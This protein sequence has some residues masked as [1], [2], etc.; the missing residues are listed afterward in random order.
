MTGNIPEKKFRAGAVSVTVWRNKSQGQRG[1]EVEYQTVS[2]E[3]CYK[4]KTGAWQNT[5]SLRVNDLPKASMALQRA[6]EHIVLKE[7]E[8]FA[9]PQH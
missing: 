1:E 8:L 7:Q 3:R 6:Y 5:N 9:P 2:I 4:D